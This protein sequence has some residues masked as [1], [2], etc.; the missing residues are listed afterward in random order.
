MGQ[1]H[2]PPSHRSSTPAEHLRVRSHLEWTRAPRIGPPPGILGDLTGKQVI[3]VGCGGGHNLAHIALHLGGS[4]VGVD[5][6]PDKIGRARC[7]YGAVPGLTFVQA[8]ALTFLRTQVPG[9]TDL[10]LSI[11]GAFSFENPAPL[12]GAAGRVLRPGGRLAL[13]LRQ[14]DATDLVLILQRR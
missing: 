4:A 12:T 3:E 9:S 7:S 5:H 1:R 8:D 2:H 14:D 13:T 11:F 10:V 6:D